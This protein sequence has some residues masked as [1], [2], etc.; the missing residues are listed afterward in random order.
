MI[1]EYLEKKRYH[2]AGTIHFRMGI[3][4]MFQNEFYRL[5]GINNK[6]KNLFYLIIRSGRVAQVPL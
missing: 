1:K 6:C 4:G 5:A 3:F 2:V